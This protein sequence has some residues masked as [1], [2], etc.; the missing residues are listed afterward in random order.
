MVHFWKQARSLRNWCGYIID[1]PEASDNIYFGGTLD[2]SGTVWFRSFKL[3]E[4]TKKTATIGEHGALA[5]RKKNSSPTTAKKFVN[6]SPV[7]LT[8]DAT[9][10]SE[11]PHG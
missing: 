4:V 6:S 2:G 9:K 7:N 1:I 5:E 11:M 3:E 10:G 8:F